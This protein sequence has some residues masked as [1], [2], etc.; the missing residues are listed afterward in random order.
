MLHLQ[1]RDRGLGA[2]LGKWILEDE[3]EKQQ[4]N[5]KVMAGTSLYSRYLLSLTSK[6]CKPHLY[7]YESNEG[8]VSGHGLNKTRDK[9]SWIKVDWHGLSKIL[10]LGA[11]P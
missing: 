8:I 7:Y 9:A 4:A 2:G 10:Y 1:G 3:L 5:V 11:V 6:S